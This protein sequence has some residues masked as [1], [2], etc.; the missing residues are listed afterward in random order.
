[1]TALYLNPI[2]DSSSSHKYDMQD[3]MTVNRHF[4]SNADLQKLINTAHISSNTRISVL[5]DRVFNHTSTFH[6]R[7]DQ[8]HLYETEGAA[9]SKSST[10][11]DRYVF[12]NWPGI[13][14]DWRG[15]TSLPKLSHGSSSLR[16]DLYT[17]GRFRDANLF[18]ASFGPKIV[19]RS[20]FVG[21]TVGTRYHPSR[22]SSKMV[23]A[24]SPKYSRA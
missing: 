13:Y 21:Q 5:L 4:G 11:S 15:Y 16:D 22:C 7:F 24:F 14:C 20:L 6:R 12:L 3:Y 8:Q 2:F 18:E 9:E 23:P 10:W 1:V 19:A 17:P